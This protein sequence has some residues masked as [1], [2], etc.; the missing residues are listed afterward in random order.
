[1]LHTYRSPHTGC[2]DAT[3]ECECE[4]VR[5]FRWMTL[6][7]TELCSKFGAGKCNNDTSVYFRRIFQ[8]MKII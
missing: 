4:K 2:I 7:M 8:L 6:N 3:R 1:M 5:A